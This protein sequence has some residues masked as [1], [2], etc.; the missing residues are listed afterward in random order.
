MKVYCYFSII[1]EIM[2]N[3]RNGTCKVEKKNAVI[4]K[5]ID[6]YKLIWN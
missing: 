4:E 5:L 1:T 3:G 2:K 6:T